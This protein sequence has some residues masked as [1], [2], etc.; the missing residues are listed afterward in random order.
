MIPHLI[1]YVDYL[2]VDCRWLIYGHRQE[3]TKKPYFI[4]DI[5]FLHAKMFLQIH[6]KHNQAHPHSS[7]HTPI[8]A[9]IH[10]NVDPSI[11]RDSVPQLTKDTRKHLVDFNCKILKTL[12]AKTQLIELTLL[13]FLEWDI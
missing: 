8:S 1:S 4:N 11:L 3:A 10:A 7:I 2:Y 5:N 12:F 9:Y 6:R 13:W